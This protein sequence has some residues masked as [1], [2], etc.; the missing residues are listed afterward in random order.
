MNPAR[1][2][3][4]VMV[5]VLGTCPAA[6]EPARKNPAL[7]EA[8]FNNLPIHFIQNRGVYPDEVKFYVLGADKTLFFARDGIT[9]RLKDKDRGWVVKLAFVGSN[10]DVHPRGEDRQ[11]AVFSYFRGPE[12]AW[13]TGLET[14]AKVVYE[15]LWPEIDLVYSCT[16]HELKYEFVVKPGANSEKIRLQFRGATGLRITESGGLRIEVP[17]GRLEDEPPV[18]WQKNDGKRLSCSGDPGFLKSIIIARTLVPTTLPWF[19]TPSE[20]FSPLA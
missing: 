13:R 3:S 17:A 12:S 4:V 15:G 1:V 8:A 18:A 16:G 7:L 14:Y 19:R 2:V 6:Q 10:P 9:F 20:L 5:L 11:A